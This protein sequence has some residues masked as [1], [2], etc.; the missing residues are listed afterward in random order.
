MTVTPLLQLPQTSRTQTQWDIPIND[1]LRLI[2]CATQDRY[3]LDFTSGNISMIAHRQIRYFMFLA[4]NVN[5][6]R[7]LTLSSIVDAL[8]NAKRFLAVYNDESTSTQNLTVKVDGNTSFSH[9]L[10]PGSGALYYVDGSQVY[11]VGQFNNV[12]GASTFSSYDISIFISGKPPSNKEVYRY[13]ATQNLRF[14]DDWAGSKGSARVSATAD[15]VFNIKRNGVSVGTVTFQPSGNAVFQTSG[16]IV[17]MA[18][19]D[20]L[21]VES[22][23]QDATLEDV[24]IVL[25]GNRV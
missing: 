4:T 8:T 6:P 12:T 7:T 11:V 3:V 22:P 21:V 1:S 10:S 20:V 9:T 17:T 13:T 24:S 23:T 2:E 16:G 18:P 19:G 25:Y 14:E 15:T 5:A